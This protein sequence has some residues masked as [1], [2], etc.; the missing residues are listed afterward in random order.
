[1]FLD[2]VPDDL[3]EGDA[4][5]GQVEAGE[6]CFVRVVIRGGEYVEVAAWIAKR[7]VSVVL[8]DK[9]RLWVVNIM[10]GLVAVGRSKRLE[11]WRT[12]T[13]V[14]ADAQGHL[15]IQVHPVGK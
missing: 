10:T 12:T 8:V 2:E 9:D 1:M 14:V 4:A 15:N 7:R 5:G 11:A 3:F 13:M 6:G